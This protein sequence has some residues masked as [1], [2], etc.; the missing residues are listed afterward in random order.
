MCSPQANPLFALMYGLPIDDDDDEP[1]KEWYDIEDQNTYDMI[2]IREEFLGR[3]HKLGKI[4]VHGHTPCKE[5]YFNMPYEINIDTAACYDGKL[6]AVSLK[7]VGDEL[8]SELFS[9]PVS[10]K[11]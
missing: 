8:E 4:V 9:V 2:W 6:S 3:E 10:K 1:K 5:A 11:S 7:M